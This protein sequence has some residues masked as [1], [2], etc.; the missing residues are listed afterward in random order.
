VT[1]TRFAEVTVTSISKKNN[2]RKLARFYFNPALQDLT[3]YFNYDAI[4]S[5]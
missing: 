5:G 3:I 1:V 4:L 2:L